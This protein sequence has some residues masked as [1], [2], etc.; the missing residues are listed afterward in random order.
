M[1]DFQDVEII[2]VHIQAGD[3]IES[4]NPLITLESDKATMDVPAPF[5]GKVENVLIK[6]GDKVSEGT[7]IVDLQTSDDA[8]AEQISTTDKKRDTQNL[9]IQQDS[10]NLSSSP[11]SPENQTDSGESTKANSFSSEPELMLMP[12]MGDF[13]EVDIIEVLVKTGDQVKPEDSVITLESDKATM[14]VPAPLKGTIQEIFVKTGQK[15]SKGQKIALILPDSE[16]ANQAIQKTD[17]NEESSV[18]EA[19]KKSSSEEK[20]STGRRPP[21]TEPI[22]HQQFLKAH[23]SPSVR[24]FARELGVDLS[25]V[26]GSG[27]KGRITHEDVQGHVKERLSAPSTD[28]SLTGT[29]PQIP[30]IDFSQFGEIEINP[31]SRIRKKGA[32]HLHRAWLNLPMVTNHDEA[33]ITELEAFRQKLKKEAAEQ[34][35]RLTMLAFLLKATA[36]NL[37]KH[38]D[39]CSSLS[40]DGQNLIHK[41]YCHIGVAVDTEE[42]LVVPVIRDVDQKGV[43]E[44]AQ[45]LGDVSEKARN[46]K[47]K[48][49][50]LQGGCFSI[51]SLGGIGGT[52]FTPLV[53]A[54]EVAIL[55]VTRSKMT[56][57]WNGEEFIPRLMLPLDLTYDHRVI[58]GAAAARFLADFCTL[59]SDMKRLLL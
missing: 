54:P 55:G 13:T 14:D 32:E 1:G 43:F 17:T 8:N 22:D 37:K 39:F 18:S 28:Q 10:G 6:V 16:T 3:R 20:T 5:S 27:R 35:I 36:A 31:L 30:E 42:G 4:E 59:L 46:R 49:E 56:P 53:N 25:R 45:N 41:R 24:K 21:V 34:N 2:E 33:D 7:P 47:L 52:A 19:P 50:D 9:E 29:V 38:P 40:P 12:D 23:A 26:N 11:E 51:S 48:R 44:L 15:I 57:Q 58:D